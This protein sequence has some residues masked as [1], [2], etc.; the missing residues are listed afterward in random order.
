MTLALALGCSR[1][2]EAEP[3]PEPLPELSEVD[4]APNTGALRR[5]TAPQYANTVRDLLG[6]PLVVPTRLEQDDASVGLFSIGARLT[7]ISPRGAELYEQAAYDL[8]EQALL[9]PDRRGDLVGCTP[10]GPDDRACAESFVAAFGRRAFR[11]ALTP[12]EVDRFAS[13]IVQAGGVTG[14]FYSGAVYGVA[15]IL[16]SPKFLFRREV[17]DRELDDGARAFSNDEMAA[18]LS[19]YLWNTTP[20]DILLDAADAGELTTDEGLRAQID[21]ML[22]DPRAR[23]GVRNFFT[24]LYKLYEL[25]TITKATEVFP[26]MS[27]EVGPAAREETLLGLEYLIFDERGDY[28]DI[29]TTRRTFVDRRLAAIYGIPAPA[30]EGF[31][32][33]TLPEDS[34][35]VGLLGQVS[36][37]AHHSHPV[38]SSPTLRGIFVRETLLCQPIPEAPADVDTSIPEPSGEAVTLRERVAEHLEVVECAGCHSLVDPIGLALENYDGLGVWRELDNGA[39]IDATGELDGVAYDGLAGLADTLRDHPRFGS[40]LTRQLYAYATGYTPERKDQDLIDALTARFV[41]ADF[42][43]LTLMTEVAMSPAFRNA[44]HPDAQSLGSTEEE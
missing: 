27:A 18:R 24:E 12:E 9:D 15:G 1:S 14:D 4:Y 44:Q 37:L 31:A 2:P 26:Q 17:G 42:D 13:L 11:R 21:R 35:R 16:Q 28:R 20:D 36:V 8:A 41:R 39:P 22:A 33:T 10:S 25:D 23:Q 34:P 38:A 40:C 6:S 43:V 19:Y 30:R 3:A 29:L 32:M 5:L 7:T